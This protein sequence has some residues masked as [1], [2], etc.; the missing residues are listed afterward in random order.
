MAISEQEQ[1]RRACLG[2]VAPPRRPA[3]SAER[4]FLWVKFPAGQSVHFSW[5]EDGEDCVSKSLTGRV[6]V[7]GSVEKILWPTATAGSGARPLMIA[8]QDLV[9]PVPEGKSPPWLGVKVGDDY[10]D[11][12]QNLIESARRDDGLY[13]ISKL[14]KYFTYDESI[15]ATRAKS[16]RVIGLL[17]NADDID[18]TPVFLSVPAQSILPLQDVMTRV[19]DQGAYPWQSVVQLTLH[20]TRLSG[21][22]REFSAIDPD[23]SKVLRIDDKEASTKYCDKFWGPL[24]KAVCPSLQQRIEA[25]AAAASDVP[26]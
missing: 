5:S 21:G 14:A 2:Q 18:D 8:Q 23:A 4:N 26:F 9:S 22:A 1:L 10:G 25:A 17:R 11:L 20:R 3:V 19:C 6:V 13:D 7:A 15:R 16:R 12:D 24:A